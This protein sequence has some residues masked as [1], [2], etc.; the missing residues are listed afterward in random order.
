MKLGTFHH[1]NQAISFSSQ[2]HHIAPRTFSI[3]LD[4]LIRHKQEKLCKQTNTAMTKHQNDKQQV[5]HGNA[6]GL[7]T[8][9]NAFQLQKRDGFDELIY[10]R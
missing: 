5:K 7:T 1:C 9:A 6:T 10:E 3:E 4:K 8:L 2:C